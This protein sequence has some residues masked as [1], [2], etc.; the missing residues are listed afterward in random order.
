MKVIRNYSKILPKNGINYL[1]PSQDFLGE[2]C[3]WHP[4]F[5]KFFWVDIHQN[6]YSSY[7]SK[8]HERTDYEVKD[9]RLTTLAPKKGGFVTTSQWGGFAELD[10]PSGKL[11]H[12]ASKIP[13]PEVT[14]DLVRY[15]DGFC[16]PMGRFVAGTYNTEDKCENSNI[17]IADSKLSPPRV[18]VPNICCTNGLVWSLDGKTFYYVDTLN[19][20]V[21]ACDYD[22]EKG[23]LSNKREII[24]KNSFI[25]GGFDGAAIDKN[26]YIWWAIFAGAKV[27]KLDPI[28]K[29]IV[30]WIDLTGE[31][32]QNPTNVCF[33]GEDY[34][35]MFVT[36]DSNQPGREDIRGIGN[37]GGI[38]VIHFDESEDVE[39]VAP[40]FWNGN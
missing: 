14:Q 27:I 19:P 6:K 2:G 40:S 4:E 7:C 1:Y 22:L 11:T 24:R 21:Y 3:T 13:V 20:I 26:G 39:G 35:T 25:E 15:N 5:N 10:H 12:W 18:L 32:M 28:S 30:G 9:H 31:G 37:N 17:F 16:D 29:E 38:A 34:R 36:S 33:G 23:T 8:T